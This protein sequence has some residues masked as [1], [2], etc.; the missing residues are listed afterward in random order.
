VK[1]SDIDL[2][3]LVVLDAIVAEGS[4]TAAARRLGVSQPAISGALRRLR[5]IFDDPLLERV[6]ARWRL[7]ALAKDMVEPLQATM[8]A[9]DATVNRRSVFDPATSHR[10]F[11]IAAADDV[12]HVLLQPL[13]QRLEQVAPGVR[14]HISP[15]DAE[16]PERLRK[17][18]LDLSIVPN[19]Y[20]A[21]RT[22]TQHLYTDVWVIALWS[23][24]RK[25]GA[26]LTREQLMQLGHA[27]VA[28]RPYT[29]TLVERTLGAL[30]QPIRVEVV[31]DG[32]GTLAALLRG[33]QRVGL[34]PY[35]FATKLQAA[36]DLRLLPSPIPLSE[37]AFAMGWTPSHARDEGHLWL[38]RMV[39]EVAAELEVSDAIVPIDQRR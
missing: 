29:V 9:I 36:G 35:R 12:S 7:S 38:R 18:Q 10:R 4:V 13:L 39:A 25:V 34:L 37:L 3:L 20:R 15:P 5:V 2:N 33:S 11:A 19:G 22:H 30:S 27:T 32:F 21:R 8:S 24:N 23:G 1:L 17:L 14:L 26:R 16:T 6:G 31:C 28:L